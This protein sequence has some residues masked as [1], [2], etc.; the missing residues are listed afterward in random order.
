MQRISPA[1]S[2]HHDSINRKPASHVAIA[3]N[4]NRHHLF[5]IHSTTFQYL[6]LHT[7]NLKYH[8]QSPPPHSHL[9]FTV[10]SSA[11]IHLLPTAR[12]TVKDGLQYVPSLQ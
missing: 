11:P 2:P 9:S 3:N 10:H 5:T 1:E 8:Y 4:N 12:I 6:S 7:G